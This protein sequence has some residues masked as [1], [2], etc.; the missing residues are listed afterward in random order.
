MS[1]L[2]QVG[3]R[4][5]YEVAVK[6]FQHGSKSGVESL[7]TLVDVSVLRRTA[8]VCSCAD[9]SSMVFGRLEAQL[10]VHAQEILAQ[11][12]IFQPMAVVQDR[13]PV[14]LFPWAV[15]GRRPLLVVDVTCQVL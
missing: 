14:S 3:R 11:L 5:T 1:F 10:E 4:T 13:L 6:Q 8:T 15:V 12:T 2:Y 7:S 9:T